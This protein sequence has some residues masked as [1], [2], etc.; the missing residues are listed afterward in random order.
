MQYIVG[1]VAFFAFLAELAARLVSSFL[2]HHAKR[3]LIIAAV[4][5][6]LSALVVA[7]YL[8][9]VSVIQSIAAVAPPQLSLAASWVIPDNFSALVSVYLSARVL[10]FAYEWNVKVLQWKL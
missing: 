4:L 10:R 6:A 8:S 9:I 3:I 2:D 1:F 5:A 7:F